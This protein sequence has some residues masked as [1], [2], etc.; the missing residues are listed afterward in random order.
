MTITTTFLM[1]VLAAYIWPFTRLA[2]MLMT[3][4]VIGSQSVPIMIRM[5]YAMAL[6]AV[7]APV[8]PKMPTTDLFSMAG[9]LITSQQ[10]LI[11]ITMGLISQMLVQAFIMA[12]QIISMQTSLGFASMVDPLNGESTPVI[13]QFYLMLGTLIFFAMDG[14]LTMIQMIAQSFITLPVSADGITISSM[15][16]IADFVSVLFQ[17]AVAFSLSA[18]IALLLINFTFGVMTRAAPQLNIFSM[19]FAVTMIGGLF[20]MWASLSGFMDHFE[21]QWQRTQSLMCDVLAL[22]CREP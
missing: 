12:G 14:H 17:T 19:G 7:I 9:F 10:V 11:G 18:T 13:G 6:T 21:M 4:I 8:L 15:R 2:S 1:A 3:M 5:F 22:S 16:S 20:I